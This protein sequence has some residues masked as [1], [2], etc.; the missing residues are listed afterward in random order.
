[1]LLIW[2]WPCGN[3]VFNIEASDSMRCQLMLCFVNGIASCEFLLMDWR[4]WCRPYQLA[5]I[6]VFCFSFSYKTHLSPN[7]KRIVIVFVVFGGDLILIVDKQIL[8]FRRARC[9]NSSKYFTLFNVHWGVVG[10]LFFK[11][12]VW[13]SLLLLVLETFDLWILEEEPKAPTVSNSLTFSSKS[14]KELLVAWF[15]KLCID[16]LW[17][18]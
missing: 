6:I 2:Q 9:S 8:K 14:I 10:H 18:F 5:S 17:F 15:Q 13:F 1:M 4:H 7:Q 16:P 12:V 11:A 3:E